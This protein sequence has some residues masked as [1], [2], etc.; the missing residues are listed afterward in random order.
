[1]RCRR[2]RQRPSSSRPRWRPRTPSRRACRSS[3]SRSRT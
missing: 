1:M 2:L 3:S